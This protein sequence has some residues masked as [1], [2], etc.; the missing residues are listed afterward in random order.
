[1]G[2][3]EEEGGEEGGMGKEGGRKGKKVEWVRRGEE[4][5]ERGMDKEEEEGGEEGGMGKE[6][7]EE[8]EERG[9]GKEGGGRGRKRNGEKR[10]RRK[11]ER[12]PAVNLLGSSLIICFI[13]SSNPISN[14]RSASSIIRHCRLRYRNPWVF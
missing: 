7:G 2:K 10:K 4:G 1:M 6:G 9:M 5:E 13:S 8:G 11:E 12:I 3:E 14:I